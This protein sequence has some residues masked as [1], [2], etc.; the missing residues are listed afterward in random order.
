MEPMDP[1]SFRKIPNHK[2]ASNSSMAIFED[3]LKKTGIGND[4]VTEVKERL[5]E[6][7]N[8][9]SNIVLIFTFDDYAVTI[10]H[11]PQS[12]IGDQYGPVLTRGA[13]DRHIIAAFSAN[14]IKEKLDFIREDAGLDSVEAESRWVDELEKIADLVKMEIAN[15]PPQDWSG[16][17]DGGVI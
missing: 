11:V 5:N 6:A 1:W 13:T 17:L 3:M 8:E 10:V 2:D 4:L 15:N 7:V 12:A 9:E 14:Y 16:M